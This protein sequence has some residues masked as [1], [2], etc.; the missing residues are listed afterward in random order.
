MYI[1]ERLSLLVNNTNP[2]KY[3]YIIHLI[4]YIMK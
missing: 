1:I 3:H 4:E 2:Y